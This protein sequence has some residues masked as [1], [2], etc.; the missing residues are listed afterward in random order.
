MYRK[1]YPWFFTITPKT[2]RYTTILKKLIKKMNSLDRLEDKNCQS[3]YFQ[4]ENLEKKETK[5]VLLPNIY[6]QSSVPNQ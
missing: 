5:R 1:V 6:K 3:N 2:G 4:E